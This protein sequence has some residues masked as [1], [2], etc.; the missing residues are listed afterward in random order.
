MTPATIACNIF[1]R[2]EV[3]A[4]GKEEKESGQE[5]SNQEESNQEKSQEKSSQETSQEKKEKVDENYAAVSAAAGS[6]AT[7]LRQRRILDGESC[8]TLVSA[9]AVKPPRTR[10]S[11]SACVDG[12]S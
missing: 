12:R 4:Y 11:E 10:T 9:E 1:D 6:S 2:K 8:R 3:I 5:E 7:L